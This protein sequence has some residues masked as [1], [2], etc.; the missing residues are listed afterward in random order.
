MM[1]RILIAMSL[2]IASAQ[3]YAI[4]ITGQLDFT[5]TANVTRSGGVYTAID[6]NGS[7]TVVINEGSFSSV[8]IGSAVT[9]TPDPWLITAPAASLWSVGGFSFDLAAVTQNDGTTVGGTGVIKNAAFDDTFG[10]WFFTTQGTNSGRFSFSATS[11]PAP[12]IALLL[13]AGLI[14]IGAVH[15]ARKSDSIAA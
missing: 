5:G 13:G 10:T 12:G 11:V 15:R 6:Y 14:A 2:A 9:M 1:K 8:A 7:P 4:P 3:S